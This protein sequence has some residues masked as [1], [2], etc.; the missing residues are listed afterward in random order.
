MCGQPMVTFWMQQSTAYWSF[1]T[2]GAP[3]NAM[4]SIRP[5]LSFKHRIIIKF[6]FVA[7]KAGTMSKN[8]KLWKLNTCS[9]I[10]CTMSVIWRHQSQIPAPGSTPLRSSAQVSGSSVG[11]CPLSLPNILSHL[12]KRRDIDPRSLGW[13]VEHGSQFLSYSTLDTVPERRKMC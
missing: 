13:R 7:L 10:L 9:I 3:K 4:R 8:T 1:H 12:K 5:C 11:S 6:V 2:V